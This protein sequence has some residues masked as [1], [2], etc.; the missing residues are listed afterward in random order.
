MALI[1]W[2]G[3]FAPEFMGPFTVSKCLGFFFSG[4]SRFSKSATHRAHL[5]VGPPPNPPPPPRLINGGSVYSKEVVDCPL[6]RL[7]QPVAGSLREGW[8]RR[9]VLSPQKRANGP[10]SPFTMAAIMSFN[11]SF[12]QF[13]GLGNCLMWVC[14]R[15]CLFFFPLHLF[16]YTDVTSP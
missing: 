6:Q 9:E 4:A 1:L 11:S 10:S 3:F 14:C 16:N 15:K 12:L 5:Y 13:L 2:A 8:S 7:W